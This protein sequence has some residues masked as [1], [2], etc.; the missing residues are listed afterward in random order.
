MWML[1]GSI[2]FIFLGKLYHYYQDSC[3]RRVLV[4]IVQAFRQSLLGRSL[5]AV[6]ERESSLEYS[7]FFR[8][9]KKLFNGIDGGMGRLAAAIARWSKTS[10]LIGLFRGVI[11]ISKQ[12]MMAW[13]FPVF[14][15][16]YVLG[17]I[18]QSRL[19]I[20]DILFLALTFF[21]AA[22]YSVGGQRIKTLWKNSLVY[23]LYI[24]MME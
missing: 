2:I 16:G 18:L 22:L 21:A 15:I 24:L 13:V 20:R 14:G 1:E 4:W 6:A 3:L 10:L 23:R 19:M 9:L 5:K 12:K 7:F 11:Q 8:K 17:R